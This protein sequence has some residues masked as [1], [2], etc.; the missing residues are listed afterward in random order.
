MNDPLRV[1]RAT[2]LAALVGSELAPG[3]WLSV[4]QDEIDEFIALTG[5]RNW[6]YT[7]AERARRE[8]DGG[9]GSYPVNC[10]LRS[11]QL[12]CRRHMPS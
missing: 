3:R 5:D 1:A 12:F 10:S 4:T 6:I 9:G 11:C 8:L 2:E 7:D